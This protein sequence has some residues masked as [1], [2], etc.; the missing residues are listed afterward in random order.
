M[1]TSIA[2]LKVLSA[3]PEGRASFASLSAD[4]QILASP[5]WFARLRALGIR[6]GSVNLFSSKLVTRDASGWA[7]TDAGRDLLARLESGERMAAG[8]PVRL[9]SSA[10]RDH[11]APPPDQAPDLLS[12]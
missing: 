6:A 8:P 11:A 1:S 10:H 4:L 7:I 12:A 2:I 3:H 5:E 9:V